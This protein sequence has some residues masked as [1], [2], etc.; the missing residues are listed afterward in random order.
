MLKNTT[1][2]ILKRAVSLD[3]KLKAWVQFPVLNDKQKQKQK[4]IHSELQVLNEGHMADLKKQ[5]FSIR[6][7]K[8]SKVIKS[9]NWERGQQTES[10]GSQLS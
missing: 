1:I 8:A 9:L 10:Q 5:F 2:I 4:G 6:S 3:S 7:T